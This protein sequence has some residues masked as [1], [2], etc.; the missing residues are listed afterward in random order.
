MNREILDHDSWEKAVNNSTEEEKRVVAATRSKRFYAYLI[1]IIPITVVV[2]IFFSIFSNFGEAFDNYFNKRGDFLSRQE[3]LSVRNQVR[4]FSLVIW[5]IYSTIMDA[6]KFEG[7]FGKYF[8]GLKVVDEYGDRLNIK[9]SFIRNFSKAI[10]YFVL[11]LG[12]IWILFDPKRQGWHDKIAKTL[13]VE[14]EK[15]IL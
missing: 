2:A 1:D 9:Q 13:V 11:W 15:V 10:S 4:M 12:F 7:S 8:M 5:I 14:D 6:S 3:F